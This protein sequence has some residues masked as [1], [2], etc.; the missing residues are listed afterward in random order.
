MLNK[1]SVQTESCDKL[2]KATLLLTVDRCLR[3]HQ[4]LMKSNMYILKQVTM[5]HLHCSENKERALTRHSLV[6]LTRARPW[7]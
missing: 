1:E 2:M 4:I 7:Y 6:M 3:C 5:I